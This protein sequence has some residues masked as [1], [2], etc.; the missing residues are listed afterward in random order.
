MSG[1]N[2]VAAN[3]LGTIGTV[4]WCIQLVPQIF[5]NWRRKDCSGLPPLMM[6][7]WA[8]SGVPFAVYFVCQKA[9]IPV[10]VQPHVFMVCAALCWAQSLYYPPKDWS[11]KKTWTTL[12]VTLVVFAGVECALVFPFIKLHDR[13]VTWPVTLVGVIAAILLAAGLLP[14]YFELWKRNGQVVG[15]NFVFLFIDSMGALF[16][17]FSLVAQDDDEFDILGCV[18]YAVVI[19]LEI[20]I[21]SSH[22]IWMIRTRKERK[23]AKQKAEEAAPGDEEEQIGSD[24]PNKKNG[25]QDEEGE[26]TETI[27]MSGEEDREAIQESSDTATTSNK[28]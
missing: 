25:G 7:L 11:A 13:G 4:L 17:I 14:P 18:L 21:F 19:F 15:I 23:L 28:N 5:Y 2:D 20:G 26:T 22:G 9:N 3:V 1:G 6:F 24:L 10:Q 27:E 16:S 12:G 8:V